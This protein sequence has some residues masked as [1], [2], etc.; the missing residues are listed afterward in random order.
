MYKGAAIQTSDA[1][2]TRCAPRVALLHTRYRRAH[3]SGLQLSLDTF[4]QSI[5]GYKLADVI[6]CDFTP[7]PDSSSGQ[8]RYLDD[9]NCDQ[10]DPKILD[11]SAITFG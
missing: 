1:C 3:C 9:N 6:S 8:H 2:R 11:K 5:T 7:E 10:H 4:N